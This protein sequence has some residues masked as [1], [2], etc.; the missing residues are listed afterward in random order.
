MEER[1]I[2]GCK[3]LTSVI[4]PES[5]TTIERLAF[6]QCERLTSLVIP[7]SV[8]RIDPTAFGECWKLSGVSRPVIMAINIKGG[9]QEGFSTIRTILK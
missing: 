2:S 3:G 7:K 1:V 6:W 4:L 5:I 8:R 9:I